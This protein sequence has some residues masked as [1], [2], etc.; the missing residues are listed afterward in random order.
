ML[1]YREV[2]E[3]HIYNNMLYCT[4]RL[5]FPGSHRMFDIKTGSSFSISAGVYI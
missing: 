1:F 2:E 3:L 5:F 4:L